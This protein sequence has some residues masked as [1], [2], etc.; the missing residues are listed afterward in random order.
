[1]RL[2]ALFLLPL[3]LALPFATMTACAEK[4]A[5]KAPPP[6]EVDVVTVA[7]TELRDTGEYLGTLL[8]R[9]SVNVL[10]QVGGYIKRIHVK[11][12]AVVKAGAPLVD[13]DA[14]EETAALE[15]AQADRSAVEARLQLARSNLQRSEAL[16]REGLAPAQEVDQAR[17]D[18]AAAQASLNA[19]SAGVSQRAVQLEFTTVRAPIDGT[20]G[21][22][23][24][25]LGDA[26]TPTTQI[27]NIAPAVDDAAASQPAV[28]KADGKADGKAAKKGGALEVTVPIPAERA[29][30]IT[31]GA[32]IEILDRQGHVIVSAPIFY[33]APQA[34]PRTQLVAVKAAFAND[35]GLRP[36]EIVRARVVYGVSQ[37]LQVPAS[38]VVRQSGQPFVF[39]VVSG[40]DGKGTALERRPVQLGRLGETAF[41]VEGGLR[42][43][44]RI[45]V[46]SLQMLKDGMPI[47]PKDVVP[48]GGPA[49]PPAKVGVE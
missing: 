6:R 11:P 5:P 44:D 23:L 20:L 1:M 34:D 40:K 27:T 39:V 4:A 26:V 21:E 33:A 19:A 2:L 22:V 12:G 8:S 28:G 13:I 14:R 35:K 16:L 18:V 7:P 48:L 17:A 41:V 15:S 10:P 9:D 32:P 46:S 37:A 24:V 3:T 42:Q 29:R 36:S 30:T 31:E 43:G 49:A 47:V 38:A 45:A 25:R